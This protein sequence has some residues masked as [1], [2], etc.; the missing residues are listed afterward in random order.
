VALFD[1][2][3]KKRNTAS[4]AKERLSIVLAHER[5]ARNGRDFIGPLKE[6]LLAVIAKYTAIDRDALQVSIEKR[7]AIDVLKV[8]VVLPDGMG[9]RAAT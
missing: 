5:I 8:D 4:V 3:F 2:F 1:I 6:E 7:D 9:K